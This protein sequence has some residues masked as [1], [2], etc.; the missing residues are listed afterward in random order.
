MLTVG[1]TFPSFQLR[2]VIGAERGREFGE[3]IA[4]FG[5]RARVDR[6]GVIRYASVSDLSVGRN[7]DEVLRILDALQSSELC[8][9]NGKQGGPTLEAA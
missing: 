7:V 8:P 2:A 9:C 5:R 6:K 4:A 3:L 1:D